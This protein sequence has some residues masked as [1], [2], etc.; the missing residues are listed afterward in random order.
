M[1]KLYSFDVLNHLGEQVSLKQFEGKAIIIVNTASKCGFT[2]QYKQ[3]QEL[4]E[5]YNEDG[6]EII[7][8]PCNQFGEQEKGSN[9]EIQSFCQLNY[10]LTFPV[11]AKIEVNGEGEHPLYTYLKNEKKGALGKRI[12]WNFT[13]FIIDRDGSVIKRFGPQINPLKMED[14]ILKA[15]KQK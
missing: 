1:S 11:Y 13:K 7:A 3:L 5:K 12:K 2:G 6:L 14:T 9:D 15:L 4:Y 8:F 10:G